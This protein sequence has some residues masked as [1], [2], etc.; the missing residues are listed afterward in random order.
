MIHITDKHVKTALA[1]YS[2]MAALGAYRGIASYNYDFKKMGN[3]KKY[4]YTNAAFRGC[5]Y[6]ILYISPFINL[7]IISKELYRLEVNLRGMKDEIDT[8]EYHE[9]F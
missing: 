4:L 2:S 1:V 7:F 6:G 3:N 9:L 5:V 8:S